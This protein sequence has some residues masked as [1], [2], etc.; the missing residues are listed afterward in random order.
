MTL[1]W[2]L[3]ETPIARS[4]TVAKPPTEGE[5]FA[6]VTGMLL[7][8]GIAYCDL[9]ARVVVLHESE[10]EQLAEVIE[11]RL[12]E[13]ASE[14]GDSQSLRERLREFIGI[15]VTGMVGGSIR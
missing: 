6:L 9:Q 4:D 8:N 12:G 7:M 15:R 13:I 3:S 11:Y 10:C 2:D 1:E 14:F 5:L